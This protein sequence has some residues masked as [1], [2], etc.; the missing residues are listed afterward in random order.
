MTNVLFESNRVLQAVGPAMRTKFAPRFQPVEI[1]RGEVLH[2]T[3]DDAEW[4]HFPQRGLVA[5][6]C[7]TTAGEGVQASVIGPEGAVG[8]FEACGSR[9]L[10]ST[11]VVRVP[12]IAVR[13]SAAFYRE[14]FASCPELRTAV[15]KHMEVLLAEARQF[16]VCNALHSVESRLARAILDALDKSHLATI[17]PVTQESLAQALGAQRTTVASQISRLQREGL[18]RSSR[19]AIEAVDRERLEKLACSC[20][21]TLAYAR[22]AIYAGASPACDELLTA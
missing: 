9:K 1:M 14:L 18:I 11:A 16:V 21:P 19:G 20:R 13:I 12:G 22:E 15:H 17:L 7:E 8:A 6:L 5:L 4:V 3:G 10:L 2:N